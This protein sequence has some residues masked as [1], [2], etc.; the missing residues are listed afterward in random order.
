MWIQSAIPEWTAQISKETKIIAGCTVIACLL[1]D[2]VVNLVFQSQAVENWICVKDKS[3]KIQT[4]AK[5]ILL[6]GNTESN[7]WYDF[8]L[9]LHF[10]CT[11]T[12]VETN[13]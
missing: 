2:I 1:W 3:V 7:R 11:L 12:N 13:Q 5:K 9:Q 10:S 4:A 6:S 8:P